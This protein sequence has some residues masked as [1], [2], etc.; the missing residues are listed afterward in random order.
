MLI[1]CLIA[2]AV[3]ALLVFLYWKLPNRRI[4]FCFCLTLG[5]AG[6]IS[7]AIFPRAAREASP[8]TEQ[9]KYD[10]Y[11]EQQVFSAW[12]SDYQQDIKRLDHNWRWYHQIL[13]EFKEDHISIQTA[14]VRLTQLDQDEQNLRKKISDLKPPME[15]SDPCYDLTIEIIRK[16]ND[17]AEAQYR[18]ITLS[19]AASDPEKLPSPEQEEQAAALE[20]VMNK[21]APAGL[22]IAGEI[23]QIR[24]ALAIPEDPSE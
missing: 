7:Y 9:Q 5:I 2:L 4:F 14:H 6:L 1:I 3:L 20:T 22:F 24:N 11:A 10:L 17:Y 12:Y 23:Q 15:L 19:K 16:T 21:E 8:M 13:E 18:A